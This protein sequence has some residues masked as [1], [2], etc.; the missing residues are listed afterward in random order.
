MELLLVLG[1][2]ALLVL[3]LMLS[4]FGRDPSKKTTEQLQS[5]LNL[6]YKKLSYCTPG[7]ELYARASKELRAVEEELERRNSATK[8]GIEAAIQNATTGMA[9]DIRLAA[10]RA[11]ERG[12]QKAEAQGKDKRKC[13]ETALVSALLDR[14]DAAPTQEAVEAAMLE[15]LPFNVLPSEAGRDALVEYIVWRDY[16]QLA[17]AEKVRTG[18]HSAA[19]KMK[20]DGADE[21][22]ADLR[23]LPFAW[24]KLLP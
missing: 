15:I 19:E 16:P 10:K 8:Q 17:D 13:S 18:I 20:A 4:N 14:M 9:D 23:S 24:T 11:Y 5:V 2:G 3:V 22:L 21:F 12:W 6:H 7:T 1:G